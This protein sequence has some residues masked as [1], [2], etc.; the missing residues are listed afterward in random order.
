MRHFQT[1]RLFRF[2]ALIVFFFGLGGFVF[3]QGAAQQFDQTLKETTITFDALNPYTNVLGQ[4]TI[5]V[6]S[7]AFHVKRRESGRKAGWTYITGNQEGS[8]QFIPYDSSQPKYEGTFKFGLSGEIPFDRHSETLP[9][10]FIIKT[11]GSDGSELTF[12]Q[13][14]FATITELSA[15]VS[16]GE[17]ARSKTD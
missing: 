13:A 9:L 14:E 8:F 5:T 11:V 15:D 16:F 10:N 1:R 4:V 7:G 17:L 12:V 6:T 3:P 2:S